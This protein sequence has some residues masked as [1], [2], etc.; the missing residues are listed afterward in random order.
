[1]NDVIKEII[2]TPYFW[3]FMYGVT[4]IIYKTI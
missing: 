4:K 1:M 2:T 3:L